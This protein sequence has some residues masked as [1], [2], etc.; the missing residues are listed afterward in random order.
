MP[1]RLTKNNK[2]VTDVRLTDKNVDKVIV[3]SDPD[4]PI[5]LRGYNLTFRLSKGIADIQYSTD[6]GRTYNSVIKDSSATTAT[7]KLPYETHI[8]VYARAAAGYVVDSSY[9]PEG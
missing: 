4:N 8:I 2:L 7:L 5:W 1:I 3:S 9:R 6:G